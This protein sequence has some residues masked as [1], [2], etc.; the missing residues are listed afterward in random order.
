MVGVSAF[1]RLDVESNTR[2]QAPEFGVVP[3]F[4]QTNVRQA[5]FIGQFLH[6]RLP[7]FLIEIAASDSQHLIHIRRLEVYRAGKL[8]AV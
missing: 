8:V 6:R 2:D 1:V 7:N 3:K 5:K 4:R